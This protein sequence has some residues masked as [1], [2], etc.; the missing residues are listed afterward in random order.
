MTTSTEALCTDLDRTIVSGLAGATD[1]GAD[2][3]CDW[4]YILKHELHRA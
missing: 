4:L 1:V 2:N 3:M